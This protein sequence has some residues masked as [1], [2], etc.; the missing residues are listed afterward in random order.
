MR[1][2]GNEK[3]GEQF[4]TLMFRVLLDAEPRTV[5]LHVSARSVA[6]P[7]ASYYSVHTTRPPRSHKNK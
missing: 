4:S 7:T 2:F 3:A 5:T 1:G 6:V